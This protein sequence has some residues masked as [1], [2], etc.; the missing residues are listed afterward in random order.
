MKCG[1]SMGASQNG[2]HP[3]FFVAHMVH[4]LV[5]LEGEH[6]LPNKWG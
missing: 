5:I 6:D 3:N 1:C 4:S 2:G